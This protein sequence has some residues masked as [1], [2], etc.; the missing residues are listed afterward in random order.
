MQFKYVGNPF[1]SL[2]SREAIVAFG[3]M[4]PRDIPVDVPDQ[5]IAKKL[6][7]N[8]HFVIVDGGTTYHV[9]PRLVLPKLVLPK[10]VNVPSPKLEPEPEPELET[11]SIENDEGSSSGGTLDKANLI[12]TADANGI[13]IDR[14]WSAGRIAEAITQAQASQE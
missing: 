9:A 12:A 7:G 14:R 11:T 10:D 6:M 8:N 5:R 13:P 2:D 1:D 4:F 3:I